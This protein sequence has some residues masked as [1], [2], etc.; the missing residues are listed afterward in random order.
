MDTK[1][2]YTPKFSDFQTYINYKINTD[3]QVSILGNISR[4]KYQM[5]PKN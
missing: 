4:N 5:V 3:W 1:A 2:D